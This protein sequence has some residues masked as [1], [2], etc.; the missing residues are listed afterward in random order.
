M[1]DGGSPCPSR[2]WM[3]PSVVEQSIAKPLTMQVRCFC[4]GRGKHTQIWYGTIQNP[5]MDQLPGCHASISSSLAPVAPLELARPR[6]SVKR[7]SVVGHSSTFLTALAAQERRVLELR[8]ELEKAETDLLRFRKQW[9]SHEVV[10]NRNLFRQREQLQQLKTARRVSGETARTPDDGRASFYVSSQRPSASPDGDRQSSADGEG[11]P[12]RWSSTR[13]TPRKVFAGSRHTKILLLLPAI[14]NAR[15]PPD[16][17]PRGR[18]DQVEKIN[19]TGA[20]F[21]SCRQTLDTQRPLDH[22]D[23]GELTRGQPR[24][25]FIETSKQLVGDLREGLWTFFED[26][27]QAT[28]GEEATG[29][30]DHCSKVQFHDRYNAKAKES[31]EE[32][33][34]TPKKPTRTLDRKQPG[35][36]SYVKLAALPPK[37]PRTV[38]KSSAAR[39][40]EFASGNGDQ[41]SDEQIKDNEDEDWDIWDTP[42]AKA[43]GSHDQAESITSD[44]LASSSTRRSSPRSSMR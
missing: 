7:T 9:A 2:D 15:I 17:A 43:S 21:P 16:Q 29:N 3:F 6:T 22:A 28:V 38:N 19:R 24:E 40:G 44:S 5:T 42:V 14:G 13:Q 20:S 8:E 11:K 1:E 36:T 26:L 25:L 31:Q 18:M 37:E 10:K 35:S 4:P 33:M 39:D 34:H 30:L 23:A 27:R 12:L 32:A 41:R